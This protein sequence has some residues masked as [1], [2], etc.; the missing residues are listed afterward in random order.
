MLKSS[1]RG[2][3]ALAV[4]ITLTGT[5]AAAPAAA[6]EILGPDATAC[7]PGTEGPAALVRIYGFKDR[8]G[9]LRVQLYGNNP[10]EFLAKGKKLKRIDL[11][12]T[13]SGDMNVCVELPRY[14][15]YAIA[16]R[17]DR[18]GNG[19][20]GWS[21]GGGFS[22]NPNISLTNLKP[23]YEDVAFAAR[24]GVTV[25]DVVLNYRRG[26]SIK[27]LVARRD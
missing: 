8:G 27:P 19:K 4:A 21:D 11:P 22:G 26:L 24:Q 14:G 1:R 5:F 7:R 13:A 25:V 6:Q 18:D 15:E 16:V 10:D 20:S 9:T 17:H 23:D 2:A 3:L 12:V